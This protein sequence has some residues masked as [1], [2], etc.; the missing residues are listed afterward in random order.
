MPTSTTK[1]SATEVTREQALA[2]R[3]R[4]QQLHR[5]ARTAAEDL[6][7]W[8]LGVQ[9][10]PAG[11]AALSLAA[12]LPRGLAAVPD[13]TD[14]RSWTSAWATR[15]A[16]VVVPRGGAVA[17]SRALWPLDDADA[18]NRLAGNGQMLKK[19]GVSSVEAIRVTAEVMAGVVA[20]PMVKGEVST[21]VS[22]LLPEEYITWCRPCQAHHLGD[23]LMRVA[24]FHAGLRLVP[25][26][27]PAT[28]A[29]IAGWPG[30]PEAQEGT[31]ALVRAYLH[32]HGPCTPADVATYLGTTQKA[33]R[34]SWPDDD[35]LVELSV[36]GDTAWALA[37]DLAALQA[38]EPDPDLVR[39]LPRSD[40][41]L[42]SKDR[43]RIVPERSAQKVLWPAL[44]WPGGVLVGTEVVAAWRAKGSGRKL[45]ITVQPFTKLTAKVRK[46]VEHEARAVAEQRGAEDLTVAFDG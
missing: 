33:V 7:V 8:A 30:V 31:D 21:E 11:S 35:D 6:D 36:D 17:L 5:P 45:A 2:Y 41:W 13:L 16:P 15:G 34:P 40:P 25:D 32:L 29:P 44:G 37:D 4:A 20:E 38:A 24:G 10:T 9:D 1:R 28:L 42:M 46:A 26:A 19:A 22:A 18:V 12:R 3:V 23:Q 43:D 27:S 14:A 39:V